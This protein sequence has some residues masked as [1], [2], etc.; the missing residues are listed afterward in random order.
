MERNPGSDNGELNVFYGGT[1]GGRKYKHRG[2]VGVGRAA[3]RVNKTASMH[4]PPAPGPLAWTAA[5]NKEIESHLN[6]G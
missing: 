5:Q 1:S 4:H 6:R 3:D 2:H